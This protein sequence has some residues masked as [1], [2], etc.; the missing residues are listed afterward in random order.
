MKQPN[1]QKFVYEISNNNMASPI[2]NL[3]DNLNYVKDDNIN[4]LINKFLK[5][6]SE[7]T[8]NTAIKSMEKLRENLKKLNPLDKNKQKQIDEFFNAI[9]ERINE[10]KVK[11]I[12]NMQ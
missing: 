8:Y 2:I 10:N 5:N 6:I 7:K 4:S 11:P 9:F 12:N 3:A 1:L